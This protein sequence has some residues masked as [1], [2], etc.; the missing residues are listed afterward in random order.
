M[1]REGTIMS[2]K[3]HTPG[4]TR[5]QFASQAAAAAAGWILTA[6]GPRRLHEMPKDRVR[7]ALRAME[8]EY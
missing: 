3:P 2:E 8:Q 1:S 4:V 5:R 7:S 6:C